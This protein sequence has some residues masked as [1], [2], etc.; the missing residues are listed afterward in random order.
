[1]EQQ[2]E[3]VWLVDSRGC[4]VAKLSKAACSEWR[5]KI[6]HVQSLKVIAMVQWCR[7]DSGEEFNQMYRCNVWE[8]P[9]TEVI[10]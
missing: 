1:M 9:L 10:F 5:E 8:I 4:R 3:G 2:G 6:P 7:D